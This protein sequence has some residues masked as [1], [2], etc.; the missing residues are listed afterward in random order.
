MTGDTLQFSN[1]LARH[2]WESRYRWHGG[3]WS[4][5]RDIGETWA[6]VAAA[7]AS[8]EPLPKRQQWYNAFLAILQDFRFL[9]G[10]RILAG[11][12][13]GQ[14]VTLFNCFVMGE[15]EDSVPGIF[16]ALGEGALTLQK[17]GGI[18]YDFSTLRARGAMARG[19]GTVA[20]GPV[21]F[22]GV[23]DAMC[24]A[25][26]STGAR[27]GAMMATL[28]CDHPDI[29]EFVGAKQTP[30]ALTR[31]N[32]SV[33]VPDRFMA[34]VRGDAPWELVFPL[35]PDESPGGGDVVY[36]QWGASHSPVPC[37]IH[38]RVSA[39]ALWEL[40]TRSAHACGE[41]GVLF[42]DRINAWNNLG[43]R[44]RIT[45]TNPCG[46]VPLPPYGACNLGSVNLSRLVSGAFTA[47]ARFDWKGLG[48]IAAVA[49]RFLDNVIDLS[50]FPLAVQAARARESRRIGLGVTG[51]A[52]ALAMLGLRYD[53]AA[54]RNF[55]GR[56]MRRLALASYSTSARLGREKGP[57]P[58]L[59]RDAYLS[60]P[61]IAALPASLRRRIAESGIRNSHLVA[62]APAG[63]ISLLA[64]N[65]SSGIEPVFRPEQRRRV[66]LPDADGGRIFR[67][68]DFAYDLWCRE[69]GAG[70][71][72]PDALVCAGEIP[73]EG[74]LLMQ[75]IVQRWVDNAVSKTI[76]M[77][78]GYPYESFRELFAQAYILGLKGI[79]V[80]RPDPLRS[81]VLSGSLPGDAHFRCDP[82]PPPG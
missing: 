52:D 79:T 47:G 27:R 66:G 37:R 20:S 7:V 22:L 5:E 77:D 61:F 30:G 73:P 82:D 68:R 23:F 29:E 41:P 50:A 81:V 49:T 1:P 38:R 10:G 51:L 70:A 45:A 2:V 56:V 12:G 67:V 18:G 40:I 54:G 35:P 62:V 71:V 44:E 69:K 9:P 15:I 21:A 31:F 74:H 6:R 34:A 24:D 33:Q 59:D 46:E 28:R 11:A 42:V 55:A 65:L 14:D 26:L 3:G 4:G 48:R 43:Y 13:T 17:G 60:T 53:S 25:M 36:R 19:S 32:L 16:R 8:V 39:T 75:A 58:A 57:F 72:P 80:F 64:G 78:P 63:S 76:N